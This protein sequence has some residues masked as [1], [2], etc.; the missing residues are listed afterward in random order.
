MS[1]LSLHDPIVSYPKDE[2]LANTLTHGLGA[3]A[4]LFASVLLVKTAIPMGGLA[5]AAYSVFGAALILLFSASALYHGST[6]PE[7][8]E[9]LRYLDHSSIYVLIAGTYTA[10]CL[11]VL[12]GPLGWA[13]F[14]AVWI[15][16]LGG[17]ALKLFFLGRF[18]ILSTVGY[19]V[20]GWIIMLAFGTLK[21]RLSPES[22]WLLV[23]GGVA[24]TVGSIFYAAKRMPWSH[25]IFHVFVLAGAACH[26]ISVLQIH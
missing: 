22:L 25:P 4:S 12:R 18:R 14:A 9:K 1:D 8:R 7:V 19:V 5:I 11:T 15:L 13:I 2:E 23:G 26:V 24:Y 10:Y 6:R 3:L 21:A 20:M 17:I 16:A